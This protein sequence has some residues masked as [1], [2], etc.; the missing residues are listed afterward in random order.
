MRRFNEGVG[1]TKKQAVSLRKRAVPRSSG[2]PEKS[3]DH[4]VVCPIS[5]ATDDWPTVRSYIQYDELLDRI[6][7]V[8]NKKL[9][10]VFEFTLAK[11]NGKPVRHSVSQVF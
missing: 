10:K 2:L 6:I 4:R 9:G 5:D 8:H 3:W 7:R 11:L 1:R